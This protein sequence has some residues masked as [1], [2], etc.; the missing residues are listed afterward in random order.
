MAAGGSLYEDGSDTGNS[1]LA[2]SFFDTIFNA[3]RGRF[4]EGTRYE[5]L[6]PSTKM[7]TNN[8]E[9]AETAYQAT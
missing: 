8:K 3:P 7:V 9:D 4:N 6:L 1:P 5:N 2:D